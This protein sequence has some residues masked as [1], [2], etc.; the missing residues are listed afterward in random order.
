[1]NRSIT[2]ISRELFGEVVLPILQREFPQETARAAFGLFGLGSEALG[3]DDELSRD[4]HWGVRIDGLVPDDV[5]I[6]RREAIQRTVCAQLPHSFQGI[7]LREGHLAGA[8]LTLDGL[9]SFLQRSIGL[10]HVPE[11]H[12]EWLQIP[13]E[14]IIHVINGEVW[15][16]PSGDFTAVRQHFQSHYPE[17]VRR[18]R[19]AHWCRYFSGMGAYALQRAILRQNEFYAATAFAKAIRWG[20]QIAFLLDRRYFPYDKWLMAYL[21]RLPR[22]GAPLFPIVEEAVRLTTGWERKLALLNEM[23]DILDA[24]MVADGLIRPHHRF[25]GSSTSGYRLL[26]HA[27]AELIQAAPEEIKDVVPL[28]DQIFLEQFHSRYVDSLDLEAWDAIL[29]LQKEGEQAQCT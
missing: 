23:A 21:Q 11:S 27:Y 29:G 20:V 1:M 9:Q 4:H 26:E 19:I 12:R 24:A 14:D 2:D 7:S 3:M 5:P 16:D 18:R 15:H 6:E 17:P 13:E 22:L 10:N 8:G 28:W 25:T